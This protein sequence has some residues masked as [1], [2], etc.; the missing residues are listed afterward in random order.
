MHIIWKDKIFI[1]NNITIMHKRFIL[2]FYISKVP[3][4]SIK[5]KIVGVQISSQT[6][7]YN[8]FYIYLRYFFFIVNR[9]YNL[10]L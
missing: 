5:L 1:Q 6:M 2:N 3:Y 7:L 10:F 4:G 8:L 9:R